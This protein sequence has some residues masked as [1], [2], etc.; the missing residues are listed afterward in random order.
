RGDLDSLASR[1]QARGFLRNYADFLGLEPQLLLDSYDER[2]RGRK[3]APRAGP[4]LEPAQRSSVQVRSLRPR[5]LSPDL[6]I[7]AGVSLAV[8]VL[9]I[10][11]GGRVMAAM[12]ERTQAEVAAAGFLLPSASPTSAPAQATAEL[13]ETNPTLGTELAALPAATV[14][15]SATP[16][17]LLSAADRVDLRI[18]VQQRAWILVQ[19]DGREAFRGRVKPGDLMEYQGERLIEVLTSNGAGLRILYEGE[20]QGLM[21]EL[22]QVVRRLWSLQGI[23]TPTPTA[24]ATPSPTPRFAP[25]LTGTATP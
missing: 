21:G 14:A 9:L 11:G 7:A 8:V 5:W 6:F 18:V 23:L 3:T 24:T 15:P 16:T 10:W 19:V 2:R 17:F 20:D 4:P 12:R 22:G 25:T 1:V 13:P